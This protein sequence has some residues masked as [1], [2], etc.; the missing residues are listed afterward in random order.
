MNILNH[1]TKSV[2]G[3]INHKSSWDS[4]ELMQGLKSDDGAIHCADLS[5]LDFTDKEYTKITSVNCCFDK[6]LFA[7]T[8]IDGSFFDG[9]FFDNSIFINVKFVYTD[10]VLCNFVNANLQNCELSRCLFNASDFTGAILKNCDFSGCGFDS[11]LLH[12]IKGMFCNFTD[13]VLINCDFTHCDTS[14]FILEN[15]TII[16]CKGL[17][18]SHIKY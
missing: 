17:N 15:T 6:S 5:V 9:C 1:F 3:V 7:G 18:D 8:T 16:N 11:E 10:F 14:S 4:S 13:A 2:I 12:P